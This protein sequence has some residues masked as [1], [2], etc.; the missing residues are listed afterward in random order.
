MGK[1]FT[2]GEK[3]YVLTGE[4]NKI[5]CKEVQE[6]VEIYNK[7]GKLLS[8]NWLTEKQIAKLKEES[9]K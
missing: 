5:N 7:S 1:F 9:K 2:I 8:Y 4:F 6:R 3:K